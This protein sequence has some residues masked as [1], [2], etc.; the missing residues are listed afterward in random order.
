MKTMT[1]R[2]FVFRFIG[3][4]LFFLAFIG[5]LNRFVDPFWYY[6]DFEL[7]G[8]NAIKGKFR[9]FER[10]VKPA[11]LIREQPEAIILGSSFSEIGF[12]PLNVHFTRHGQLKSM[13]FA[14]AG[15]SF[16]MV[17]CEFEF[18]L[19]HASV[20]RALVGIHPEAMPKADC[21]KKFATI[22][23]VSVSELLFSSRALSAS[24]QTI[25]GQKKDKPSH[26]REG[27]YFYIRGK[28]GTDHQFKEFFSRQAKTNTQCLQVASISSKTPQPL[29]EKAIDLS[30]LQYLIDLANKHH[31]ELVLFAYP[32][33]A[34]S[35]ELDQQCGKQDER[36]QVMKQIA[37]LNEQ[38]TTGRVAF[39]QF[40]GY[41]NFTAEP[42][43]ATS[44]MYWQ[45]PEHFNFEIGN[46]M[47]ADM[48]NDTGSPPKSGRLIGFKNIDEDYQKFLQER[49]EYLQV[50]PEVQ[51][52]LQKLLPGK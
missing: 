44:A 13:N 15:A 31:V 39:W 43:G 25:I 26:T 47:L 5:A 49:I 38:Q 16:E 30:G 28:A 12:D 36:W 23:Q 24:V 10:D 8:F 19:T 1:S 33:H 27:M 45:D 34:Y 17:Q 9:R 50:H 18:A 46:L 48:F 37:R 11:L 4:S 32:R 40:Y 14:L 51:A 41:N 7:Q 22:G 3:A 2:Q 29:P 42:I 52:N 35:L 21:A 20:K 6:R